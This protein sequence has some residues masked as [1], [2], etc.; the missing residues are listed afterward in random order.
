MWSSQAGYV[1]TARLLPPA[2]PA[3]YVERPRL[4]DRLDEAGRRPLTALLA[5]TGYGKSTTLSA[6]AQ[7]RRLCW[8]SCSTED[9]GL[10]TLLRGLTAALRTRVTSLP[11]ELTSAVR[12]SAGPDTDDADRADALAALLAEAL[13]AAGGEDLHLVIDDAEQLPPDSGGARLLAGLIRQAPARLRLL[14]ATRDQL[15]VSLRHASDLDEITGPELAFTVAETHELLSGAGI[16]DQPAVDALHAATAGW[17]AAVRLAAEALR[18][19]SGQDV[20]RTLRRLSR[21]GGRLYTLLVDEVLTRLPDTERTLLARLAIM[22]RVT[23]ELCAMLG[24]DDPEASLVELE[25]RGLL[26]DLDDAE[27]WRTLP[28]MV[29]D[30]VLRADPL[31]A[32]QRRPVAATAADWLSANGLLEDALEV[33]RSAG[34]PAHVARLL[35]E[36]GRQ[37][38]TNGSCSTVV[39]AVAALPEHARTDDLHLI[40][41]HARQVLGD[42]E[43]ALQAFARATDAH[44]LLP[45]SVAWRMGLIHH[46]RGELDTAIATYDRGLEDHSDD[47]VDRTHLLAW[48]ATARWLLGDVEGCRAFAAEAAE[49][50]RRTADPATL[51]ISHTTQA[52]LAA[53]DGDRRANDF[54]YLKALAAAEE[55]GDVLQLL[56]IRCNRGSRHLEEGAYHDALEELELAL[57]LAEAS[58]YAALHGLTLCNRAE[59]TRRL[60]RL[61]EAVADYEAARAL[62]QRIESRL[63]GY[64]ISGLGD[65]HRL[66]GDLTLA[67]AAYEEAVEV[68][69]AA[70]DAQGLGPA[71]AG[72]ARVIAASDP[73]AARATAMRASEV[74]G[75]LAQV[76]A[77]LAAGFVALAAGDTAAAADQATRAS[78]VARTRRDRAG[79][80]EALELAAL[81]QDDRSAAIAALEEARGIWEVLDEPLGAARTALAAARLSGSVT[82]R[83]EAAVAERRLQDLGVGP[84]AADAAGTLREIA[85][86]RDGTIEVQALGGF[87]VRR[88]GVSVPVSAWQSRKARDLCKILIARRGRPVAREQLIATLWPDEDPQRA[89]SRLS[90]VLSVARAVFDPEKAH[91]PDTFLVADRSTV[92]IDLERIEVDVETFLATAAEGLALRARGA[93]RATL[94]LEQAEATYA[95]ELFEEDPYEDWAAPLREEARATYVAVARAVAEDAL[96]EADADR[97]V[98]YLLRVLERD[99]YDERAH[100]DLV[101]AL[102][103]DGRHGEARRRYRSYLSR[104]DEL[105]VPGESLAGIIG[106]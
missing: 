28:P 25:R 97:A 78:E 91:G 68:L 93:R 83:T 39:D 96:A 45:A 13:D 84:R 4:T 73:D 74:G 12:G 66:R 29:R 30:A 51:A 22:P 10:L 9:A 63:V 56:R 35:T 67:R 49:L 54:H 21:P 102:A 59:A 26:L 16:H 106:R 18:D 64:A 27:G 6:W 36:H 7:E 60:G 98:R 41:G 38:V 104:M 34:D 40:D 81:T 17:P 72:L 94:L 11:P 46:F 103:A 33:L 65:V 52:L 48:S 53:T 71:L 50:A 23:A 14:I 77:S 100:H 76:T 42:W 55:A 69:E 99:P 20:E 70:G 37:L 105:G 5:G 80:A 61:E 90:G 86:R 32:D 79:L 43:G 87:T 19:R 58:G 75:G 8:Y 62:Y 15:P 85:V 1:P 101:R 88:G 2:L 82:S 31:D 57:R 44:E 47:E 95:G 89:A 24:A 3:L 92:A